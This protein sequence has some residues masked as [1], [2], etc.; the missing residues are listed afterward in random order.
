MERWDWYWPSEGPV[1]LYMLHLHPA[2]NKHDPGMPDLPL[3]S[4]LL[5]AVVVQLSGDPDMHVPA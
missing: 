4:Q 3:Y 1:G 5:S 2:A